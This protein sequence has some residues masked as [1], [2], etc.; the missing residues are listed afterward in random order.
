M[1]TTIVFGNDSVDVLHTLETRA[2]HVSVKRSACVEFVIG[3]VSRSLRGVTQSGDTQKPLLL[4]S[5]Q[6][7]LQHVELSVKGVEGD[8]FEIQ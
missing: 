2:G 8:I 1:K 5:M 7:I 3:M 4:T 6:T